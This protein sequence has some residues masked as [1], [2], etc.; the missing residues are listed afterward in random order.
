MYTTTTSSNGPN[1]AI[2]TH[3][4]PIT[5]S[6]NCHYERTISYNR[7]SIKRTVTTTKTYVVIVGFFIDIYR[8]IDF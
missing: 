6:S 7:T 5:S 2:K 3:H 4:K 1:T 8:R